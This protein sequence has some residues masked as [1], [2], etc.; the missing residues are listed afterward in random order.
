[1]APAVAEIPGPDD[2]VAVSGIVQDR[3]SAT[4]I[5]VKMV[6]EQPYI[7]A[8]WSAGKNYAAGQALAKKSNN[9]WTIVKMTSG[10]FTGSAL[11]ALGVPAPTAKALVV[12][13]KR[14]QH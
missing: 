11:T 1:M 10:I 9:G 12:D 13:L 8:Y 14:T 2:A 3:L 6:A 5:D 7:V 4:D